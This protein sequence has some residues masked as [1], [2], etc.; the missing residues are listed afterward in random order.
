MRDP[1]IQ[2]DNCTILYYI[3]ALIC[4]YL[5]TS[6]VEQAPPIEC[7]LQSVYFFTQFYN[8]R[9]VFLTDF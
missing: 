1:W 8:D 3:A 5:I 4:A 9:D 2:R 7:I 6:E